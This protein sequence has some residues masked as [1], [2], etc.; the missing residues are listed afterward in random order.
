MPLQP[1]I[2]LIPADKQS[3]LE[4]EFMTVLHEDLEKVDIFFHSMLINFDGQF[5]SLKLQI[6]NMNRMYDAST[7]FLP[8]S[9]AS[10]PHFQ[11]AL[12]F[13]AIKSRIVVFLH[14][15]LLFCPSSFFFSLL[16]FSFFFLFLPL[17]SHFSELF[18]IRG[19]KLFFLHFSMVVVCRISSGSRRGYLP[20]SALR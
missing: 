2:N 6:T 14:F 17:V 9:S 13:V 15:L 1:F 10:V 18:S 5:N 20:I 12:P 4:I 11:S 3:V 19:F 8:S 16:F 7:F